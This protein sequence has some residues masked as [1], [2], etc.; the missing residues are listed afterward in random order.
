[1]KPTYIII[2]LLVLTLLI[3]LNQASA[4][5]APAMYGGLSWIGWASIAVVVSGL[6]F[7][8]LVGD[9]APDFPPVAP[10]GVPEE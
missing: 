9:S 10:E 7:L 4:S 6:G 2:C 3:W 8:V 5:A 1:M